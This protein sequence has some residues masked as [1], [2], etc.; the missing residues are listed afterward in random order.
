MLDD[1]APRSKLVAPSRSSSFYIENLLRTAGAEDRVETPGFK[2]GAP[3][4]PLACSGLEKRSLSQGEE[5]NWRTTFPNTA[6]GGSES[7]FI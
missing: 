3:H 1:K 2:L 4:N 5:L 7:K 6:Q